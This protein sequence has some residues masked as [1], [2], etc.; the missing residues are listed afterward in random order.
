[1]GPPTSPN[2]S[3]VGDNVNI[4]ARLESETK[5]HGCTLIVS[6]ALAGAAGVDLSAHPVHEAELR[7]RGGCVRVHA[8]D[9]PRE[10]LD[11][12][13]AAAFASKAARAGLPVR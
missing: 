3:A 6:T 13:S 7:G 8:I 2:L 4:A 1:M 12:G 11:P 9:D 5:T 10:L